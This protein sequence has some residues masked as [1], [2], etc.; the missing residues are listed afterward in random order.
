MRDSDSTRPFSSAMY[1]AAD[2]PLPE[3]SATSTPMRV[4]DSGSRS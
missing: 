1:R 3:T 2:V 4:S